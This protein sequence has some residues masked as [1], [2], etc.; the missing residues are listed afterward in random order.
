MNDFA[1]VLGYTNRSV[2]DTKVVSLEKLIDVGVR[3]TLKCSVG[4]ETIDGVV[5]TSQSCAK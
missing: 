3:A 5:V 2:E 4:D 1:T